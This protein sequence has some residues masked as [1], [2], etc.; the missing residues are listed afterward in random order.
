MRLFYILITF[1]LVS[2]I[3]LAT[4]GQNARITYKCVGVNTYG[5]TL[6]LYRDCNG[7][8]LGNTQN[9]SYSSNCGNGNLT[10]NRISITDV[11]TQCV[12]QQSACNGG[13][14]SFGVEKYIYTRTFTFPNGCND[15]Q[16]DYNLCC[17]SNSL[18]SISNPGSEQ[19]YTRTVFNNNLSTCNNSPVFNT[20][21]IL[22]T[23]VNQFYSVSLD[24]RDIDG[25]TF[26]YELSNPL[27]TNGLPMGYIGGYDYLNPFG[28]GNGSSI[29]LDANSGLLCFQSST[30]EVTPVG[31]TVREY[32]NSIE[33]ATYYLEYYVQI[34][35]ATNPIP[36]IGSNSISCNDLDVNFTQTSPSVTEIDGDSLELTAGD[37]FCFTL[38]FNDPPFASNPIILS[39]TSNAEQIL[40]G[41]TYTITNNNSNNLSAELCWTPTNADTGKHY[42]TF[43][44]FD[45][46]A[47]PIRYKRDYVYDITVNENTLGVNQVE[48]NKI[49]IFPNPAKE[50][51]SVTGFNAIFNYT[52]YDL[53]GKVILT[54]NSQNYIKNC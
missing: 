2:Q 33:I 48:A 13:N 11:T 27:G 49:K 34:L 14:G 37:N 53:S 25:D 45:E 4:H 39:T 36:Y 15:I 16:L 51:I 41:A 10:F 5:M 52:L 38:D 31:I 32:R 6:E 40:N 28:I 24:V 21:T 17:R 7:V 44:V 42:V 20:D 1:F 22:T 35:G 8:N 30:T 9:V 18:T 23:A 46:N 19:L 47:C 29:N 12:T 26:T 54:G 3:A 50:T 43:S